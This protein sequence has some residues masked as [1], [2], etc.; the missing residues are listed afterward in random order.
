[1]YRRRE[2]NVLFHPNLSGN[3]NDFTSKVIAD[4]ISDRLT[5]ENI[6]PQKPPKTDKV[7]S[8]DN[9]Y[10]N[11]FTQPSR[12]A[13]NKLPY[14]V[15]PLE[16]TLELKLKFEEFEI[17]LHRYYQPENASQ[18]LAMVTFL[19]NQGEENLLDKKLEWLRK[20]DRIRSGSYYLSEVKT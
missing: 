1:V 12:K 6:I 4:S 16:K 15:D 9:A 3:N 7:S 11:L 5:H 2:E 14:S 18:I 8:N 17:L 10:H 13:S 20:L 19:V